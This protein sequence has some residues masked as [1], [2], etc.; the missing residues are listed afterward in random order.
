MRD[1]PDSTGLLP[2]I[3]VPTLV[4][5]GEEDEA[6]PPALSRAMAAAIPGAALTVIPGAGHVSPLEA[7]L[8]VTRVIAEFLEGVPR[9]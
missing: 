9:P 2:S 5:V 1:R 6:T 3:D 8:T 7:P 4:I